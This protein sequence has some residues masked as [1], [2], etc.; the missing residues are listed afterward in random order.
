MAV[1]TAER[2]GVEG[3]LTSTPPLEKQC[4]GAMVVGTGLNLIRSNSTARICLVAPGYLLWKSATSSGACTLS[5]GSQVLYSAPKSFHFIKYHSFWFIILLSRIS[6]TTHSSL[7]LTI[8]GSGGRGGRHLTMGSSG[9]VVSL[10]T[11]KTW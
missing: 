11:L 3:P 9:A 5:Q 7:P 8:S 2:F 4:L 1:G 10:T 6:S